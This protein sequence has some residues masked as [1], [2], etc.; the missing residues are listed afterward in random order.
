MSQQTLGWFFV[1]K[2][3]GAAYTELLYLGLPRAM[4]CNRFAFCR[5]RG[6]P[7][8]LRPDA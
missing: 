6:L 7:Q 5:I 2:E 4:E 1:P 8:S 3:R